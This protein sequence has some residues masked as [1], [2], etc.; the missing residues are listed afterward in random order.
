MCSTTTGE[1]LTTAVSLNIHD[2]TGGNLLFPNDQDKCPQ[3][4][5]ISHISYYY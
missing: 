1:A 2:P 4:Y 3:G 5:Y